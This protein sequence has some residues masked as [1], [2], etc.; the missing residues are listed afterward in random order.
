M[1]QPRNQRRNTKG[2][3]SHLLC[4]THRTHSSKTASRQC[5]NATKLKIYMFLRMFK[6]PLDKAVKY[7]ILIFP[8]P[9]TTVQ[10]Q[11]EAHQWADYDTIFC[12][13]TVR[14]C[15][16]NSWCWALPQEILLELGSDLIWSGNP[17]T[18][19]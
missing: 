6:V 9:S 12:H 16:W 11:T 14:I 1:G 4:A 2:N 7:Q 3:Q 5:Q 17:S 8:S 10:R 19:M 15:P 13:G 18:G